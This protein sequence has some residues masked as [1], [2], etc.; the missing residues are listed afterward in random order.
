MDHQLVHAVEK[1][2]GWS[3]PGRLGV[4]F[5]RGSMPDPNLCAR[6]L[7]PTRLLDLIMRRSLTSPQFRCFQNG[8]ELHPNNYLTVATTRRGQNL[9][10]AD[11]RKL[12]R[13][14]QSGC[15]LVLDTVGTFDP[16]M[17]VTCRAWQWWSH[18]LVQVNAYLAT[19]DTAGFTLHW[20]DH[21]VLIVQLAGEKDW[22][23]RGR[24]RPVPMYRDAAQ[25]R[26]PSEDVIWSGTLSAGEVMHIPRG[27]WHQATRI[28]LGDG[29]SLHVTFGFV[30]RTGVDWLTWLADRSR[31]DEL[32][33]HDLD[34]W[35]S[36]DE[37][38]TQEEMLAAAE[39]RLVASRFPSDF[40]AAR[41]YEQ[42]PHR[43]VATG[44]IFGAPSAVVCVT[45]FPPRLE[46]HGETIDVLAAGKKITFAAKAIPP[47]CRLLSGQPVG[48]AET[49]AA[50]GVDAA[51]LANVLVT[52]G[53]CA[54][55]TSELLSGYTGLAT[56]GDFLKEH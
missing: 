33:R 36:P 15:T 52:E 37:W 27:Y 18:E 30:R 42:P 34:R 46:R 1:A 2:L 41:E 19:Q 44:G 14:M 3:G 23:V 16:T 9:Q 5:A 40:L 25:N 31:E 13:L 49:T 22:E 53:I 39:S 21:D 38:A 24:S 32:F 28:G 6:V 10:M 29:F 12:A 20:D 26:T 56:N 11:M 51:I 8:R 48:L 54:E 45:E 47:L 4:G 43:Q 35:D 55:L 7:T 50:C 17:E